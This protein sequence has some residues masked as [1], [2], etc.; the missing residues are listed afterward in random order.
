GSSPDDHPCRRHP[1]KHRTAGESEGVPER[2][3]G[4]PAPAQRSAEAG[5]RGAPAEF[6][7]DSSPG[8]IRARLGVVADSADTP[9]RLAASRGIVVAM[10]P[11]S[12]GA[13]E[14]AEGAQEP[15][16]AAV[17]PAAGGEILRWPSRMQVS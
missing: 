4:P 15:P 17:A 5:A 10:I 8:E 9:D 6:A 13:E 14:C 1:Q 12:P 3:P 7:Q 2:G 11:R 16:V